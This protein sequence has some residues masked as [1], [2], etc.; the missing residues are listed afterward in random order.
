MK[1]PWKVVVG[2]RGEEKKK[3]NLNLSAHRTS[4]LWTPEKFAAECIN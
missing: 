4:E 1:E 3:L 2:G